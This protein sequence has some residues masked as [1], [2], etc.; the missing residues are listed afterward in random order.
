[1]SSKRT[2]TLEKKVLLIDDEPSVTSALSRLMNKDYITYTANNTK[3]AR[4]ILSQHKDIFVIISDNIMPNENGISFFKKLNKNK[5]ICKILMTGKGDYQT[6][7]DA[8]NS[9]HIDYY[10]DKPIDYEL[11]HRTLTKIFDSHPLKL[12]TPREKQIISILSEGYSTEE[13]SHLLRISPITFAV[14]KRNILNK[15]GITKDTLLTSA[16]DY[17]AKSRNMFFYIFTFLHWNI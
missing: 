10:F 1:M 12:L 4:A 17:I 9:A 6:A 15:I 8:I 11:L 13:V 2:N 5:Y 3:E 16:I 7:I 14:H